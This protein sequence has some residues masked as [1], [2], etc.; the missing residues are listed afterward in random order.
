[1]LNRMRF[2]GHILR[3]NE[4]KIPKKVLNMKVKK[5]TNRETSIK[6]GTC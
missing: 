2:Y 5:K 1:M 3:M 6:M 4:E